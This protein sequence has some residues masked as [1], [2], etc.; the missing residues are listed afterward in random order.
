MSVLG[1]RFL[2]CIPGKHLLIPVRVGPSPA[3]VPFSTGRRPE[4]LEEAEWGP[5]FT[6][7]L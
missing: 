2:A 5:V 6:L 3:L 4:G 1:L 7:L